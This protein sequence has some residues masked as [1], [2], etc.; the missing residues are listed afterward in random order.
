VKD[1]GDVALGTSYQ[2]VCLIPVEVAFVFF[3][4]PLRRNIYKLCHGPLCCGLHLVD[5]VLHMQARF[6]HLWLKLSQLPQSWQILQLE[7]A[8]LKHD[9]LFPS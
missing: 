5:F 1:A 6:E 3:D 2:N 8:V 7:E 4:V 9:G